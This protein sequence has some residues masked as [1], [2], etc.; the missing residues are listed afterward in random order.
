M[1]VQFH[2]THP[3]NGAR[4]RG[5]FLCQGLCAY[6]PRKS[7][8]SLIDAYGDGHRADVCIV[9]EHGFDFGGGLRVLQGE[10]I[11]CRPTAADQ[12]REAQKGSCLADPPTP[13]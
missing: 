12:S 9:D 6:G 4:Q 10:R 13:E 3:L 8:D 7:R 11:Q 1:K 5:G 2:S